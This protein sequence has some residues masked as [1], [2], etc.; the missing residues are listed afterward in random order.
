MS[1]ALSRSSRWNASF[2]FLLACSVAAF[3]LGCFA[4]PACAQTSESIHFYARP[5]RVYEGDAVLFLYREDLSEIKRTNI[6]SFKWDYDNDGTWDFIGTTNSLNQTWYATYRAS[7]PQTVQGIFMPKPRLQIT[8][9]LP[10]DVATTTT[11]IVGMTEDLYGDSGIEPSLLISKRTT[12][13]QDLRL[14]L[15]ASARLLASNPT[16]RVQ[17]TA[18]VNWLKPGE[19]RNAEWFID[20]PTNG[21]PS[22]N[23][24]APG[25]LSTLSWPFTNAGEYSIAL[26]ISYV[27]NGSDT[28]LSLTKSNAAFIKVLPSNAATEEL[29]L[30]R[31]YRRGFPEEYG[32]DDIVKAYDVSDEYDE[33]YVYFRHLVNAYIDWRGHLSTNAPP[34]ASDLQ[35]LAEIVNEVL[36]GQTL[37]GSQRLIEALR[38]KYPRLDNF[39]P[40]HPPERLPV[41]PGAREQTA[42]IDVALLDF[43][44][45][46]TTVAEMIHANGASALRSRAPEGG[47]PYPDFP[48]Y[49]Q[50]SDVTLSPF[51]I[52]AKNEYWQMTTCFDQL[53]L[54]TVEKAKRLFRYS[55]QDASARQE[56]KEE[57]KKAGLQGYLG[58]ALLAS[59]QSTNNFALNQGNSLLAHINN[60]R[61]LFNQIN[62][63]LNPLGNDGSFIPNESFAVTYRNATEAVADAREAEMTARQED[64]TYD[65][66]Q[67]ALR[68]EQLAQRTS[69]ITPLRLLTGIDPA[70]YNNLQT[71]DNQL[72]YRAAVRS[73]VATLQ[74]SYPNVSASGYGEYG[75]Q[76]IAIL[77]AGQAIEQSIKRLNNLYESIKI[78][79]WANTEVHD[80][81]EGNVRS[82]QAKDIALGVYESISY[83]SPPPQVLVWPGR[84][85][86]GLKDAYEREVNFILE[87]KIVNV[88]LEEQVRKSL[89]DVANLHIDIIRS[90]NS[91][92]QQQLKLESMLTQMD[93]Y[94]EDLAHTRDT[95]ANLYFQDPSFRVVVS[96][97]QKRADDELD[98][99]VDRLYRLAKTLEY[100]WTEGYQNPVIIPVSSWESASLENPL[101][102]KFTALDSLFNLRSADEAKDYLDALKAWDSKLRRINVTSVRGPNHAGPYTAEP[103]SVR[104]KILNLQTTGAN[105]LS[106]NDSILKFRNWLA[107]QRT[108]STTNPANPPVQFTFATSI[109]DNNMFP[110]T[111]AEWNMRL[112]TIR[113]DLVAESGFSS[114]QVAEIDLTMGGMASLRRFWADPPGADDLFNLTF[115]P[116]RI[117]RSAFT[118]KVPAR[119]NG[120]MGG[121]PASEFEAAGLADRPIAATQW[122]FAIDTTKPSNRNIDFTKL[123]DIVIRFTY[124]YGNP[125]ELFAF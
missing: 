71:V 115:N 38:I 82:L 18:E 102:D 121:R 36:Q 32:W 73:R 54:G 91:L 74:A 39:D 85:W 8:Y 103:I 116:G 120:A 46:L 81:Q 61:D 31:A 15:S 99:A 40:E 52:P 97:A 95:A 112:H 44:A 7:G 113:V 59:G 110:A 101:F 41:P 83:S 26:R 94:I 28:V 104:E 68:N 19:V 51:P 64:R 124:T 50:F 60:S 117:D 21:P 98:Y 65:Q 34:S 57:C 22:T 96:Q 76:V 12:A 25:E 6:V 67:A 2:Q 35:T 125:P 86:A 92:D 100:E 11:N 89:L 108:N 1:Y 72:A 14:N 106:L 78:S 16:N 17:L 29:S 55:M 10:G 42:S 63:G 105:A 37:L 107:Q 3:A 13:N 62:A 27:T 88:R 53:A 70:L 75:A 119:I 66:Y 111:G 33:H 5:Y 90:R 109:A 122:I 87:T 45:A 69:Y 114:S 49:I 58:M 80:L 77:D 30:G 56:A 24:I 93:R 84:I 43:H 79:E 20:L 47:E 4:L 9:R 123:K 23:V 48:R 118:I